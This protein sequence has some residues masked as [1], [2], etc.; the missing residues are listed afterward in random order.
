MKELEESIRDDTVIVSVMFVNNEIGAVEDIKKISELIKSKNKNIIFHV[1][2]I[3]AYGKYKIVPKKL[4]IDLMSVSGHK[5]HGP[6][7][8]GY[9]YIK[10]Y[11]K[12]EKIW[13]SISK[14]SLDLVCRIRNKFGYGVE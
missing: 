13:F 3:Q 10:E 4:G 6:K 8:S 1:D 5:I 12:K 14:I 11:T 7:G 9:I 2:A